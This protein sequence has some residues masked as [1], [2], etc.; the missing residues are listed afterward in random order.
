MRH[1]KEKALEHI[2]ERLEYHLEDIS[3]FVIEKKISKEELEIVL[4][5][6][7]KDIL[8]MKALFEGER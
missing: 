4:K 3:W 1:M 8:D 2:K 5:E 7:L 6:V